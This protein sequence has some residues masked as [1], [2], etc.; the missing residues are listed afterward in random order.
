MGKATYCNAEMTYVP[1]DK[2]FQPY[3]KSSPA[4]PLCSAHNISN[5]FHGWLLLTFQA[6]AG[7]LRPQQGTLTAQICRSLL[8]ALPVTLSTEPCY[9]C[10]LKQSR[11]PVSD[12]LIELFTSL[13][14]A[15]PRRECKPH[16][17]S[18]QP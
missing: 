14:F 13:L 7:T 1:A 5:F 12:A 18:G 8:L 6:A 10:P 9:I 11:K 4:P 16:E 15:Y 3:R 2:H 17:R